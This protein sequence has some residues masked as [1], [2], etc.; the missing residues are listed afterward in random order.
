MAKTFA[1]GALSGLPNTQT[2]PKFL[3]ATAARAVNGAPL[4]TELLKPERKQDLDT[5][6]WEWK[7]WIF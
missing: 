2:T 6:L 3:K 7:S 4:L 1:R 5:Y